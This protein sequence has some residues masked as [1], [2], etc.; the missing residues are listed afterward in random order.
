M[1]KHQMKPAKVYKWQIEQKKHQDECREKELARLN[2]L[3]NPGQKLLTC[4][5]CGKICRVPQWQA[6]ITHLGHGSHPGEIRG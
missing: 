4:S 2:A 5:T 1:S 3:L 6:M